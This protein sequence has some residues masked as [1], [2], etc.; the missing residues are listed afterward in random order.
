MRVHGPPRGLGTEAPVCS[1]KEMTQVCEAVG[2]GCGAGKDARQSC[3][4]PRNWPALPLSMATRRGRA[5]LAAENVDHSSPRH[6][7]TQALPLG[8]PVPPPRTEHLGQQGPPGHVPPCSLWG[9][10]Q[11]ARGNSLYMSPE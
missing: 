11:F 4:L 2:A 8:G 10:E 7:A 9:G 6:L 5:T 3:S 1:P